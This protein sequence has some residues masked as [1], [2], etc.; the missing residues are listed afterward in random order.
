MRSTWACVQL[1]VAMSTVHLLKLCQTTPRHF[2]G[3]LG[4]RWTNRNT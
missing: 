4:V 3:S 2:K 1:N